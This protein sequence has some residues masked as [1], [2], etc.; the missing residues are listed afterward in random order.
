M[1]V[2]GPR[3]ATAS[4]EIYD[5]E[6]DAWTPAGELSAARAFAVALGLGGAGVLVAGGEGNSVFAD[7]SSRVDR[8]DP[9]TG[10]WAEEPLLAEG[11]VAPLDTVLPDGRL[12]IGM[13]YGHYLAALGEIRATDSG[14]WSSTA[15][16]TD[17][18]LDYALAAI[19]P[20]GGTTLHLACGG[21]PTT[22]DPA[23][24]WKADCF[25]VLEDGAIV[26]APPMLER[27]VGHTATPL[28][29]GRV[30]VVGSAERSDR[31]LSYETELYER[32]P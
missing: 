20:L 5:P 24:Y 8:F 21:S 16:P 3:E 10:M 32:F 12:W 30:L 6:L 15:S 31:E 14:V 11:R 27:R 19:A 25:L 2:F 18:P 26:D 29:D 17:T 1:N 23:Q 7:E 4:V 28:A 9:S 22:I 13:G